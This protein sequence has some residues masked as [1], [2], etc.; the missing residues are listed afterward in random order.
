MWGEMYGPN[1]KVSDSAY[2]A[3]ISRSSR[4]LAETVMSRELERVTEARLWLFDLIEMVAWGWSIH[5]GQQCNCP[6]EGLEDPVVRVRAAAMAARALIEATGQDLLDFARE[7]A[8]TAAEFGRQ[9]LTSPEL[10]KAVE[11]ALVERHE[12]LAERHESRRKRLR[13]PSPFAP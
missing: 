5:G 10:A 11:T 4:D 12:E 13:S 6:L 1:W 3:E 9:I 8:E 2:L 7:H